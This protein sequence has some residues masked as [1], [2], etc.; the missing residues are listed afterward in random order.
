M[1]HLA[2]MIYSRLHGMLTSMS[3]ALLLN[4]VRLQPR[5]LFVLVHSVF[6]LNLCPLKFKNMLIQNLHPPQFYTTKTNFTFSL[7]LSYSIIQACLMIQVFVNCDVPLAIP[8]PIDPISL[9]HELD[10]LPDDSLIY[11]SF[12][13]KSFA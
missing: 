1:M 4:S 11:V 3:T 5:V 8:G 7:A 6:L 10:V 13:H 2:I 12:A 9:N